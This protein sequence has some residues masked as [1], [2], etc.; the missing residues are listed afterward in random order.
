V[1]GGLANAVEAFAFGDPDAAYLKVSN[2]AIFG[3]LTQGG[4]SGS[5][6]QGGDGLGG[7]IFVGSGTVMLEAVLVN[8]NQSQGGAD[9]QQN[10][11]GNGLGGGVYVDPS[12]TVTAD[13]ETVIAG[14]QA[15]KSN[16]DIWGT[17]SIVP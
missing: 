4:T 10:T 11:T 5:G 13:M 7:G 3:N 2:C 12:A 15:T 16:N 6:P 1:G 9:S 17:I 8:G 14:N